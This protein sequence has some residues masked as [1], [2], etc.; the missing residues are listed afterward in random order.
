M[1]ES[2][3]GKLRVLID[4][5]EDGLETDEIYGFEWIIKKMRKLIK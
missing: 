2:T 1:T 3:K 4:T 5:L